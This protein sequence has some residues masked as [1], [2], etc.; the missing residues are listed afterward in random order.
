MLFLNNDDVARVIDMPLCL[1]SLES[2]FQEL[3]RRDA[4]GMGRMDMYVPSGEEAPYH[5]LALMVGGS[6]KD[7][8]ACIRIIS[9]MVSWP[10]VHGRRR[11]NKYAREPGTWCG[12]L[13]LFSTRDATPVAMMNDGRLQ[14]DRVGAGAGLGAKYLA[15][16]NSRTVAMIGSGGMA[17]S[18]LDALCRVRPIDRVVVFSLNPANARE[19]AEEMQAR[20]DIEVAV[21]PDGRSAVRGADIV[22]CCASAIEPVFFI[23]WLEPGMCVIDVNRN[24]VEPG[25]LHAVDVA[26]RPG[27][28]TPYL[29]KL[30]PEAFYARGGYLGYVAGQEEERA[31][32]PRVDL[33][34]EVVDIPKLPDLMSGR[35]PGR[36]SPEQTTWFMNI[37]A[38]G[39]QFSAITGAVYERAREQGLGQEIPTELFLEDI[40]A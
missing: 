5:R 12:L 8:Y 31:L 30:P 38:I 22:C 16:E 15:R 20:H 28:A 17:R 33:T 14:H 9:D 18:Y 36:T 40:R 3:A 13:L 1:D 2:L 24:S 10:V 34:P 25:F 26:V 29:E 35:I 32:V 27:D 39:P 21:A 6:R 4:V 11:E 19:Y 23:D 7:G 37:G